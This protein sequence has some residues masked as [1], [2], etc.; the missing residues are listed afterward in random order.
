MVAEISFLLEGGKKMKN[1]GKIH[2]AIFGL[3]FFL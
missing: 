3:I 2:N 1:V